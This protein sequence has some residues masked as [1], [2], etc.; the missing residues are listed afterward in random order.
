MVYLFFPN[1]RMELVLLL[2]TL[3]QR[4]VLRTPEG[5]KVP[6]G[7]LTGDTITVRPDEYSLTMERRGDL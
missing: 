4:F 7:Q 1:H 6:S 5:C 3:I 2:A